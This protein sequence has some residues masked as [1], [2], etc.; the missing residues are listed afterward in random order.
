MFS[1]FLTM[2]VTYHRLATLNADAVAA[3]NSQQEFEDGQ[4]K[5]YF[6]SIERSTLS[7]YE[8]ISDGIHWGELVEPLRQISPW[9]ELVFAL[10]V[11]LTVLAMMNIVMGIFVDSVMRTTDASKKRELIAKMK[12]LFEM[13]DQDG[14]GFLDWEEFEGQLQNPDM[15]HFLKEI[16]LDE[17]GASDLFKLLD[18]EDADEISAA[19]FVSGCARL[20][21]AAK[22][23]DLAVIQHEQRLFTASFNG[24]SDLVERSLSWQA[25]SLQNVMELEAQRL[26]VMEEQRASVLDGKQSRRTQKG[27]RAVPAGPVRIRR[28]SV[29]NTPID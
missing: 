9:L 8:M 26:S 12:R 29:K 27:K 23:M 24:F 14:S 5:R 28:A 3:Q 11:A 19:D 22:A 20:S 6:G 18:V 7:L 15:Q 10:Y 16:D 13:S 4:L 25:D 2:V 21:G 1:I 17:Q